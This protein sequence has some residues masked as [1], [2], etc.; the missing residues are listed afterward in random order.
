M[1]N[2]KKNGFINLCCIVF[3]SQ[4]KTTHLPQK[5]LIKSKL[6]LYLARNYTSSKTLKMQIE[7][8]FTYPLC[9]FQHMYANFFHLTVVITKLCKSFI[10]CCTFFN[11][12]CAQSITQICNIRRIIYPNFFLVKNVFLH[13]AIVKL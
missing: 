4:L 9:F 6:P 10:G 2:K 11:S 7:L 8:I 13:Y 3:F 5:I 12:N 1:R